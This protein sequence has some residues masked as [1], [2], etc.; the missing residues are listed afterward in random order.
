M[1]RQFALSSIILLALIVVGISLK[2]R[3]QDD[4]AQAGI[5]TPITLPW[6]TPPNY[7]IVYLVSD[8]TAA[9][10][11]VVAPSRLEEALGVRTV[12]SWDGVLAQE[13]QGLVD[14]LILHNSAI[15]A[16]EK[17]WLKN[18]YRRGVVIAAINIYA[19]TLAELLD[20]PGIAKDGF[21]S[22][23]YSGE[24]FVVV[25][26]LVLGKPEDVIRVQEALDSGT[27]EPTIQSNNSVISTWG[28]SQDQ[29]TYPDSPTRFA[30]VL[31][32]HLEDIKSTKEDYENSVDLNTP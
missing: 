16:V 1:S 11:S 8:R 10:Q 31:V 28:R 24:F 6:T 20:A 19:P 13:R 5:P 32:S 30:L 27:D 22:E 12:T 17:A 9:E 3:F 18:A 7:R 2:L 29:L 21:A 15:S 25:S 23:P 4:T 14:S 26:R